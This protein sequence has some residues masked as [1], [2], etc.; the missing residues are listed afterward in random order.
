MKEHFVASGFIVLMT[1][2]FLLYPAAAQQ[3]APAGGVPVKMVVT[4][5]ARHGTNPAP[6]TRDDVMV[7]EGNSRDQVT[8]WVPARGEHAALEL[9]VLVDDAAGASLGT[10]LDDLR[11]FINSQAATTK[12]GVAYMQN[13]IAQIV[14][15]LT[16]DHTQAAKSL[17]LPLEEAGI[18]A[19]PYFSLS[20]LIKRWPASEARREVL[21][22]SDGIDRYYGIGDMLD[23]Y[24]AD[25]VEQAQKAGIIVFAIYNPGAGHWGH[26]YWLNYWGQMYLSQVTGQTGGE[27]YYIGFY[28]P[29]VNFT[30][31]LDNVDHRLSNQYFL[32]FQAKPQKK[33]GMQRVKL[34]T[35][36]SNT[37]L[38]A[39]DHVFVPASQ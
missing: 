18:N 9:F 13:G 30:P 10:Q 20:D 31:Y 22:V 3:G 24:V 39:A 25:A 14:Q 26:N 36:L 12:V 27:S 28:G 16:S 37:D 6:V 5:E 2:A 17:R 8:S 1:M 35:E 7:Y 15:N 11:Q 34:T 32:S 29:A 21:M 4:A 19:S 23:P 33:S 38:V